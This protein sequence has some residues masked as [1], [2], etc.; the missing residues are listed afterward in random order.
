M[1]TRNHDMCEKVVGHSIACRLMP[2]K[3]AIV[4]DMILNMVQTKNILVTL[5][6][7]SLRNISNIKQVYNICVQNDN[8]IR[9]DKTERQ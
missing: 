9:G 6:R 8:I 3:K 2:E 1:C 4:S 7:K 5:K